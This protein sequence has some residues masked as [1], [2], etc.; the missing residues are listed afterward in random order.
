MA[1]LNGYH[2]HAIDGAIGHV[3]DFILDDTKWSIRYLIIDTRNW[4]VGQ[5]VL[6]SP[7]AVREISWSEHE[8]R[9]DVSRDR[10]KASPPWNPAEIITEAYEKGLHGYYGWPG[11]GW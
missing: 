4:W 8:V 2:I 3:E 6:V 1:A 11:Y 7:Y 10:I 9:L 5:H